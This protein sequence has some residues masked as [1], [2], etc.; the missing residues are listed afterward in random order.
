MISK[1]KNNKILSVLVVIYLLLLSINYYNYVKD[2]PYKRLPI[3]EDYETAEKYEGFNDYAID[4]VEGIFPEVEVRENIFP[5]SAIGEK[6]YPEFEL[7]EKAY[8]FNEQNVL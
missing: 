8:V 7:R 1:F 4:F 3:I 6:I 5:G 2:N